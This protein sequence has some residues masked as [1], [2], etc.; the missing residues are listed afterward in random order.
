MAGGPPTGTPVREVETAYPE[1][2]T[3][4]GFRGRFASLSGVRVISWDA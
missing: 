4:A 3:E 2:A 1:E